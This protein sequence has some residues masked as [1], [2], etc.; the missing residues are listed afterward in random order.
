MSKCILIY[1]DEMEI[2]FLCKTILEKYNYQVHTISCCEDVLGDINLIKPDIIL[3]DLWIPQIGGAKAVGLIK[4]DLQTKEIPVILFS[5]N[6]DIKEICDQVNADGYLEKP[7]NIT[8]LINVI[9]EN[10]L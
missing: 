4:N 1:D 7:F 8:T 2:L 3:M 5:A 9:E 6:T 10:I